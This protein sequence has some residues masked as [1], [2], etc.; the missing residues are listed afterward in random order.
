MKEKKEIEIDGVKYIRA[1]Q[2][3]KIQK[4]EKLWL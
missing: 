4:A 3:S 1:D 2:V